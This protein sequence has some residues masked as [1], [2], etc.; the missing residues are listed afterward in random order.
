MIDDLI[1][2]GFYVW[3]NMMRDMNNVNDWGSFPYVYYMGIGGDGSEI[4]PAVDGN[5][6]RPGWNIVS[7]DKFRRMAGITDRIKP[8]KSLKQF[9]FV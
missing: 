6:N 1:A 9:K 4:S 5:Y 8:I 7:V 3:G 2:G